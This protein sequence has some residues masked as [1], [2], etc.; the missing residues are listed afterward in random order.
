MN[1]YQL[2]VGRGL[3]D[4]C[5]L[6]RSLTGMKAGPLEPLNETRNPKGQT[7]LQIIAFGGYKIRP[8]QM[9]PFSD[10]VAI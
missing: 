10:W 7:Q 9:K 4:A 3:T 5:T 2:T 6:T 1:L 8:F